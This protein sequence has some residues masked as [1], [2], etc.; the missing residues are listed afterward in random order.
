M[1][2]HNF[3]RSPTLRT[4]IRCINIFQVKYFGKHKVIS[5]GMMYFGSTVVRGR[6]IKSSLA[7]VVFD[8]A[9]K[10]G[11]MLELAPFGGG[12]LWKEGFEWTLKIQG[13]GANCKF[14]ALLKAL[15]FC[16]PE[17]VLLTLP[18]GIYSAFVL[19]LT[20]GANSSIYQI[21]ILSSKQRALENV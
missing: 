3:S 10:F 19:L 6:N 17:N 9:C 14:S 16:R 13:V 5:R 2:C 18:L 4:F 12:G 20:K 21:C 7:L 8:S 1:L 15:S 11:R